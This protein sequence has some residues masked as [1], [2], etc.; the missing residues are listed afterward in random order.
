M[1]EGLKDENGQIK[2]PILFSLIGGAGLVGYLLLK[3]SGSTSSATPTASTG[4]ST[5]LTGAIAALQAAID[6]AT[7][8][9]GGSGTGGGTGTTSLDPPIL[10]PGGGSGPIINPN[11]TQGSTGGS[12]TTKTPGTVVTGT[13]ATAVRTPISPT[14]IPGTLLT[15][16]ARRPAATQIIPIGII[17][18]GTAGE[19]GVSGG[20]GQGLV[21]VPTPASVVG[22]LYGGLTNILTNPIAAIVG[23]AHPQQASTTTR[24]IVGGKAAIRTLPKVVAP[25]VHGRATPPK[26]GVATPIDVKA[27]PGGPAAIRTLPKVTVPTGGAGPKDQ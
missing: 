22:S 6:G 21:V 23:G 2:K 12:T 24:A 27:V 10:K 26:G 17:P 19:N 20:G 14:T 15:T 8:A 11:P 4:Q 1:L 5:D 7:G 18:A 25:P 16:S 3:G 13:K 9:T